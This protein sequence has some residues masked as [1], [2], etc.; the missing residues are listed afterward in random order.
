ML[1]LMGKKVRAQA[2]DSSLQLTIAFEC[3]SS[4]QSSGE[5]EPVKGGGGE[6]WNVF[7]P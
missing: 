6:S 3:E 2:G 5:K 7:P 1:G 4:S